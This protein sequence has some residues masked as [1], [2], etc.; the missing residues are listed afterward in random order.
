MGLLEPLQLR[1]HFFGMRR[2]APRDEERSLIVAV[3]EV[4]CRLRREF[5]DGRAAQSPVGDEQRAF[6]T[7]ARSGNRSLCAFHDNAHKGCKVGLMEAEGE[8]RRAG[9]RHLVT[10][11]AQIIVSLSMWCSARGEGH[12]VKHFLPCFT[13]FREMH[14][15]RIV[16]ALQFGHRHLRTHLHPK[17]LCL[18]G[19]AENDA[20][21][22]LRTGKY[23]LVLLCDERDTMR[24][25]PR[26]S[27]GWR[28]GAKQAFEQFRS[29]RV[30]LHQIGDAG[31]GIGYIAT[32][33]TAHLDF[34]QH[35]LC[36]FK[37]HHVGGGKQFFEMDGE[38]EAC[39]S[40][41]NDGHFGHEDMIFRKVEEKDGVRRDNFARRFIKEIILSISRRCEDVA[42][43]PPTKG[44]RGDR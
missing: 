28:K 40:S 44:W 21:G 8:K 36:A 18:S 22:T 11:C 3:E 41:A 19:E 32:S 31:K 26:I 30:D 38:E 29:A 12:S 33:A 16:H 37:N 24:F 42:L 34:R 35:P 13:P 1:R 6:A 9:C 10:Q 27:I 20:V 15:P 25:K 17:T 14:S 5:E 2:A 7:K 4:A 23:A 39:G 43:R